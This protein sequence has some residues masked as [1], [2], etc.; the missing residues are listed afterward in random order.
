[1]FHTR[2]QGIQLKCK[3]ALDASQ[4]GLPGWDLE[5]V[6][7]TAWC[8]VTTLATAPLPTAHSAPLE[9]SLL[10]LKQELLHLQS[11]PTLSVQNTFPLVTHLVCILTSSGLG[12]ACCS[13][14]PLLTPYFKL[15]PYSYA[16]TPQSFLLLYLSWGIQ[17]NLCFTYLLSPLSACL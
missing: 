7:A 14:K 9:V 5:T 17:H 10:L 3:S 4:F 8:P 15:N 1:M 12:K 11:L 16:I 6:S 2:A 13:L